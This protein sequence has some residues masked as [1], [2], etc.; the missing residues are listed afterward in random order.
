MAQTLQFYRSGNTMGMVS[1]FRGLSY[2]MPDQ[3]ISRMAKEDFGMSVDLHLHPN[4]TQNPLAPMPDEKGISDDRI[5]GEY[6]RAY[7]EFETSKNTL[8]QIDDRYKSTMESLRTVILNFG[9]TVSN[10][11]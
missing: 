10:Q 6:R 7:D 5:R 1:L 8:T 2:V 9:K 3:T 11:P 4:F